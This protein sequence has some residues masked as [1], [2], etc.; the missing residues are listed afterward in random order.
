MKWKFNLLCC[1]LKAIKT[2]WL[3][4]ISW[5]ADANI[6]RRMKEIPHVNHFAKCTTNINKFV[7][8][9]YNDETYHLYSQGLWDADL[10][11]EFIT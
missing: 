8:G 2:G 4:Y 11:I 9:T 10:S 7:T 5:H 6:I 3:S 1:H